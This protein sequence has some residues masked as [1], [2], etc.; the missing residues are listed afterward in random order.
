MD[1]FLI[2]LLYQVLLELAL[3]LK[4]LHSIFFTVYSFSVILCLLLQCF[5]DDAEVS[6]LV[7]GHVD[8]VR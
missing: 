4:L 5:L 6:S 7:L 2:I 1:E 3:G 8:I